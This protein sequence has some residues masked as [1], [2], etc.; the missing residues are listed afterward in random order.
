MEAI[1]LI[2]S[3]AVVGQELAAEF[4]PLPPSLLPV[5]VRRL[6]EL[7]A[8][9]LRP[10]KKK[11]AA[12]NLWLVLPETFALS[13]YDGAWLA[14]AGIQ[15]L[16]IPTGLT[17]GEAIVYALN[18]IGV[19]DTPLHILHGDTLID[20]PPLDALD[21]IVTAERPNDYSWAEAEIDED[22][23]IRS[24]AT[25]SAGERGQGRP[26]VAG[27]FALGSSLEFLRALTRMRGDFI[28]A[29]N[30]Y[31]A[32]R[33][34][35]AETARN[36]LDFGHLQTFFQSRLAVTTARGFN[37]LVVDGVTVRKSSRDKLKMWAEAS[38]Y[39]AVP[40]EVQIYSARLLDVGSDGDVGYYQTQYEYL[41]VLSELFVF[42]AL[43]QQS[44]V[45]VLAHCEDFLRCCAGLHR[46]DP[47]D[48]DLRTFTAGKTTERL[49]EFA[50]QSGFD[51]D[52]PLTYA[53]QPCPSLSAM[54]ERL[55]QI[56]P[57]ERDRPAAIVHGDFCFSNILYDSRT[58]RIRVIDPRG[59]IGGKASIYGDL[60]Y[61]LAK[62][63]HSIVG[64][65]DQIVA[66]RYRVQA[67]G[68]DYSLQ[69]EDNPAQAWLQAG[70]G[71]LVVDGCNGLD[72]AVR[73][74]MTGLFL[75]MLPLHADRPDRQQA[76][77]AN[78]MRLFLELDR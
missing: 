43:G 27:Y 78:A 36:W 72:P 22:G 1:R 15:V 45:R 14:E 73:A 77:L 61:D 54:A 51:I 49:Q 56:T 6:Y 37:N 50:R 8:E 16:Q 21:V 33:P 9:A 53:G 29:L 4:G 42:G 3:G 52:Q 12:Q 13:P 20:A 10:S 35:T 60:R 70:L 17:L 31:L 30:H 7:Q 69:F 63:A 68:T 19:G 44:W 71:D 62:L 32:V 38:W 5:G 11:K 74:V 57:T 58:R 75:S 28:G 59:L 48:L 25:V 34:V 18:S 55:A 64:R 23:R 24:L 41:P 26:V 46:T 76:F 2:M 47:P 66:G 65:Y 40:M 67:A 39:Q